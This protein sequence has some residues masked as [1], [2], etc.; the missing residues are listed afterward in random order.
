MLIGS[1]RGA[2]MTDSTVSPA[3]TRRASPGRPLTG[4]PRRPAAKGTT[5]DRVTTVLVD[6]IRRHRLAPGSVLPSEVQ[7]STDLGV[8]RGAVREAYRSLS[9]AGL[10]EITNGRS[11]RVG[12]ISKR[13]LLQL[14]EHAL[15]TQQAS[16][17]QILDLRRSIEEHAAALAA[18]HRT[19]EDVEQL[20]R[21][22]AGL[23]AAGRRTEPYVRAD[24]RFHEIIGRATGNPLIALV[25]GGLREAMGTSIRVSLAGRQSEA[26]LSRVVATHARVVDAI[27]AGRAADARRLMARHFDEALASVRRQTTSPVG[28]VKSGPPRRRAGR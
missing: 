15:W 6:H 26:E 11:P 21:A 7:M 18:V 12:L 8:S 23:R 17:E 3:A 16:I 5:V 9:Q 20:R 4:L 27:E 1:I 14:V 19:D 10:V 25:T 2:L 28:P 13:A 22:V 24:I